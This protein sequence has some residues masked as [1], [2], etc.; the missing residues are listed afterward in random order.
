MGSQMAGQQNYVMNCTKIDGSVVALGG[1]M[2]DNDQTAVCAR[3]TPPS[4]NGANLARSAL[5]LKLV[6]WLDRCLIPA[7]RFSTARSGAGALARTRS[8]QIGRASCRERV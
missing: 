1:L 2:A 4:A 8:A 5:V 7:L 3:Y 6:L